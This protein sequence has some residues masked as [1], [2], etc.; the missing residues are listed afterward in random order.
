MG[1]RSSVVR[2]HTLTLVVFA[3]VFVGLE[4]FS[5]TR[6]SATWDEP[7]HV[8]DG[9]LSLTAGDFRADVEHP[10]LMRMWAALP[11]ARYAL[12]VDTRTI[13][14]E[15]GYTWS[16]NALFPAAHRFMYVDNDADA[17]LYRA[18]LM[19]VLL[20]AALGALVYFRAFALFGWGIAAAVLA[21][22]VAEPNLASHARLVTTDYAVALTLAG[23]VFC[24]WRL[25]QRWTWTCLAGLTMFVVASVLVKFSGLLVAPVLALLLTIAVVQRRLTPSR[26]VLG[27]VV[28]IVASI[29]GIWAC[30]GFRYLPS[31]NPTWRYR[32]HVEP[33]ARDSM[34][35]LTA[36]VRWIDEHHLLPNAYS[37][38]L[39]LNRA[40]SQRRKAYLAG[41]YSE[42]GWW[43]YFPAAFLLKTPLALLLLAALGSAIVIRR[44]RAEAPWLLLPIALFMGAAMAAPINIGLRHVL[45]IYPFVLLLAGAGLQALLSAGRGA[46]VAGAAALALAIVEPALV[47]PHTLAFFNVIAGGPSN[48]SAYLL[49]SNLDWGQDLKGLKRWMA[50]HNVATINLAYFGFADPKYYGIDCQLLPGSASWTAADQVGLPRLPGY[51][52]VSATLL[53]GV[54]A[55][56]PAEREFYLRLARLRP[57]TT[58]GHSI[59]VFRLEQPWWRDPE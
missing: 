26:A 27:G 41:A 24:A 4:A 56:T 59:F 9:Y 10:P 18:R 55:E 53:R 2:R 23:S 45:P 7:V 43:Y 12:T 36:S 34:P 29:V 5:L 44:F 51:V 58:I 21:L 47:Y 57:V 33:F 40:R 46:A 50:Q 28:L 25:S 31:D 22:F 30:Y 16:L 15:S 48:G 3:V 38:G 35:A 37:E 39:L 11:L 32:F 8:M 49:D 1:P 52:A 54:Y 6:E 17:L 13:D 42:T 19:T 20:G 14:Q